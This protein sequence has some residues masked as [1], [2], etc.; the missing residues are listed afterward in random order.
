MLSLSATT[1]KSWQRRVQSWIN[2]VSETVVFVQKQIRFPAL[3][4]GFLYDTMAATAEDATNTK[5]HLGDICQQ[6]LASAV[7]S[8]CNRC[9]S[10]SSEST[11]KWSC[12]HSSKQA[13]KWNKWRKREEMED[14]REQRWSRHCGCVDSKMG[15]DNCV[16]WAEKR[17]LMKESPGFTPVQHI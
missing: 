1:I 15:C 7:I 4:D 16:K 14:N 11:A 9:L 2:I 10:L 8:I 3:N 6:N 12:I 5:C 13:A 17:I